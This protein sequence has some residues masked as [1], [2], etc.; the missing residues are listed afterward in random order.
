MALAP[1]LGVGKRG[2]ADEAGRRNKSL[3]A[4]PLSQQ[5]HTD[6]AQ[7][8]LVP[9]PGRLHIRARVRAGLKGDF[10]RQTKATSQIR[11]ARLGCRHAQVLLNGAVAQLGERRVR[12]AKVRG[13]NP[14][15][16]TTLFQPTTQ[17]L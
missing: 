12:N 13:S 3:C 9:K 15:G 17:G 11:G 2:F 16:S 5:P 10:G 7:Q 6:G 1:P 8:R 4:D 14:L